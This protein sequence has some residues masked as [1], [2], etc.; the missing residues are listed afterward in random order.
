MEDHIANKVYHVEVLPPKQNSEKLDE[1]LERFADKYARVLE[2][3]YCCCITDNA[4]GH[5]AF[6]G[7]EL[8]EELD[9]EVSTDHVMIHLNTFHT[10][11]D[12]NTILGVC[13]DRGIHVQLG[14]ENAERYRAPLGLPEFPNRRV[15]RY[16]RWFDFMVY[17]GKRPVSTLLRSYLSKRLAAHPRLLRWY[18]YH[19]DHGVLLLAKRALKRLVGRPAKKGVAVQGG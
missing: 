18:R 12:L 10:I 7:T 11:E 13:V 9:L 2:S 14:E 6:Q 15:E 8:I 19:T 17:R 16:F 4:M 1:D 5:L 3:G